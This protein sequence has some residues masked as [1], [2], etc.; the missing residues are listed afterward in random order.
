MNTAPKIDE[1]LNPKDFQSL[2]IVFRWIKNITARTEINRPDSASLLSF[3]KNGLTIELD[4][5]SGA[6]GHKLMFEIAVK[7]PGQKEHWSFDATAKI[8][9]VNKLDDGRQS[10]ELLLVQFEEKSWQKLL[11]VYQRRQ[12]EIIEFFKMV[13]G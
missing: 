9:T 10:Y 13:K 4:S 2:D 8:L 6:V 12:Q 5:G 1:I 3:D 7:E 11:N